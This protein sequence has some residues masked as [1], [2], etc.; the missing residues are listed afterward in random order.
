MVK[1]KQ[2]QKSKV[3]NKIDSVMIKKNN[4]RITTIQKTKQRKPRT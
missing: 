3:E 1:D 4:K 2:T